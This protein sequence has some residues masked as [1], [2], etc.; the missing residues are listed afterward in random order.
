MHPSSLTIEK[1]AVILK[2]LTPFYVTHQLVF[3]RPS[4][5]EKHKFLS[6]LPEG[7]T[8]PIQHVKQADLC[9][10]LKTRLTDR[11]ID[12]MMYEIHPCEL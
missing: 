4:H 2:A 5:D 11:R 6:F 3:A 7:R 1:Y 12:S 10:I 8:L 9:P